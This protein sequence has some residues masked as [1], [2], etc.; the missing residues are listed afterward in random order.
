MSPN[1]ISSKKPSIYYKLP[2]NFLRKNNFSSNSNHFIYREI[3]NNIEIQSFVRR[4]IKETLLSIYEITEQQYIKRQPE[5]KDLLSIQCM[6]PTELVNPEKYKQEQQQKAWEKEERDRM[7]KWKEIQLAK[8]EK[9]VSQK[10]ENKENRMVET[11][12]N[13]EN[14]RVIINKTCCI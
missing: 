4:Q 3:N 7:K 14:K 11:R 6:F 2:Q 13:K 8:F 9:N 1:N 5:K 10:E 12:R